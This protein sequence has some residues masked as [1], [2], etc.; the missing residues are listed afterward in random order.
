MNLP[1]GI[2]EEQVQD[3][4]HRYQ[5]QKLA[6]FGSWV[7]YENMPPQADIDMLVEFVSDAPLS[8]FNLGNIQTELTDIFKRP[9]DLRTLATMSSDLHKQ[10][11]KFV[12]IYERT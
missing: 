8:L 1:K 12:T 10:I 11:S 4:C 6:V 9:V 5:I 3:L 2:S 7:E